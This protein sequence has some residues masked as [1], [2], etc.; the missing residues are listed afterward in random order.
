MRVK[1]ST[2][3]QKKRSLLHQSA[4]TP[5]MY[6]S[7]EGYKINEESKVVYY[8]IELGFQFGDETEII[9]C[10]KRYSE[11]YQLE[12]NIRPIFKNE[13]NQPVFPP[14]KIFNNTCKM[15][16]EKRSDGLQKYL[17]V[18]SQYQSILRSAVFKEFFNIR[19]EN[20]SGSS[21]AAS[22]FT[23]SS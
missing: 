3:T 21:S 8:S 18:L 19:M 9:K 20:I 10:V 14:K 17:G 15:F 2:L 13:L 6:I 23:E 7:V 11:L 22:S 1:T 12:Q 16:L 5:P 4:T